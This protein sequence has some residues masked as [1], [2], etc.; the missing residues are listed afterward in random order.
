[1][2][3]T[4]FTVTTIFG[5][6]N[7]PTYR[8]AIVV[9]PGGD[10]NNPQLID[11]SI[12][13]DSSDAPLCDAAFAAADLNGFGF[14]V[15]LTALN[16]NTGTPQVTVKINGAGGVIVSYTLENG[17]SVAFTDNTQLGGTAV[18][19]ITVTPD[20]ISDFEVFGI[21]NLNM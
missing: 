17:E 20:T 7:G 5:I 14:L 18:T 8:G 2:I 1:M 3:G 4:N 12:V 19:S 9:P 6:D 15:A 11:Q 10:G 21:L 16:A 13:H